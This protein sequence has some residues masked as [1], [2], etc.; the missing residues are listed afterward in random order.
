MVPQLECLIRCFKIHFL[1]RE[2]GGPPDPFC[3]TSPL[4]CRVMPL[5]HHRDHLLFWQ[6]TKVGHLQ[7][8]FCSDTKIFF[9]PVSEDIRRHH[10][11]SDILSHSVLLKTCEYSFVAFLHKFMLRFYSA[12]FCTGGCNSRLRNYFI[13]YQQSSSFRP[14]QQH[15]LVRNSTLDILC[16]HYFRSTLT[17]TV[18]P[19]LQCW[20]S[21]KD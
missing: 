12:F 5:H 10:W 18:A 19:F 6:L 8:S 1:F 17:P 16:K 4:F 20:Q 7:R 3:C 11:K 9:L 14:S 13:F 15:E 21:T 2:T